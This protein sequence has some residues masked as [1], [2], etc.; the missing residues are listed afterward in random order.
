[1]RHAL[2]ALLLVLVVA[3]AG[4]RQSPS[5]K[6]RAEKEK[7]ERQEQSNKAQQ[8]R[9]AFVAELAGPHRAVVL[10][11]DR[12]MTWTSQVQEAFMPADGSPVAGRAG[13]TDVE[14][15]GKVFII[16]L[17]Y[18]RLTGPTTVLMLRCDPPS[19][20]PSRSSVFEQGDRMS[21]GFGS[22]YAFVAK[23]DSVK[24]RRDAVVSN[25]QPDVLRT[26]WTAEGKCLA[27]RKMPVDEKP[28]AAKPLR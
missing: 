18:G 3:P 17:V 23:I 6:E 20:L 16:R 2:V 19:D 24:V 9:R 4:C 14:R 1:M 28:A 26:G 5:P 11:S 25:G 27:L 7:A 12:E 8:E 10:D 13:L 21:V 22:H 15:D